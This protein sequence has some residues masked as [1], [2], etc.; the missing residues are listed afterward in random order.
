MFAQ[1]GERHRGALFGKITFDFVQ[2]ITYKAKVKI[3]DTGILINSIIEGDTG[4]K[5]LQPS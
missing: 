2:K 3:V 4:S 1:I 5:F